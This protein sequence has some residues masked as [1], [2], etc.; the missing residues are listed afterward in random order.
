[1]K[2]TG[3]AIVPPPTAAELPKV[4]PELLASVPAATWS[5]EGIG[6]ILG[7]VDL[8]NPDASIDRI[9]N[10]VDYGHASIGVFDGG[11]RSA[12]RRLDG[13]RTRFRDRP[14]G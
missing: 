1:M 7:K 13:L 11:L 5:N 12:G 14:D 2:V 8:A 4:T 9:L 6:K 10:F 3:H